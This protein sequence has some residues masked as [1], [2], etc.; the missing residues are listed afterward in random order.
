MLI[1]KKTYLSGYL[2]VYLSLILTVLISLCLTLILG[3]RENTRRMQIESVTD[4]GMNNLLAEYHRELLKQYNLFF[5]DTSYGTNVASYEESARHLKY[6]VHMN[7]ER[8]DIFLSSLLYRDLLKLK[9]DSVRVLNVSVASDEDGAVLRRQAV[10]VMKQ[11]IGLTYIQEVRDWYAIVQTYDMTQRDI[12]QE[13]KQAR[14]ELENWYG[15]IA[16]EY[17][18]EMEVHREIPGD[19][20]ASVWEAGLLNLIVDDIAT[21]SNLSVDL[22]S[23]IS[24]RIL[25][26]G[27]GIPEYIVFEDNW[28]DQLLFHEYVLSYTGR[29]DHSK[30]QSLLKYQTEY[31]LVGNPNDIQ[32]L[33]SIAYKLLALRGAA[34][35]VYLTSDKEKMKL[36]ELTAQILSSFLLIPEA[37]P[38]MQTVLVLTWA[39]AESLYDVTQ[40]FHGNKIPL[41]KSKESWHYSLDEILGFGWDQMLPQRESGLC[42]AD[43][44]RILLC[45]QDKKTTTFRLMDIMEM[46]IRQTKGNR[47]FRMDGSIDSIRAALEFSGKDGKTYTIERSYGY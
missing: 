37:A 28:I 22:T 29:Y 41:I 17:D 7:L 40:L 36:I 15:S 14:L 24:T 44:L 18:S 32:N 27:S 43:Y 12:Y 10:E 6:Y 11:K 21:L 1:M 20:V 23:Y 39:M 3:V 33:K 45:L 34:N 35:M 31:I 19:T 42:Y 9:V 26:S 4:I 47:F 13:Q 8:K 5:I 16:S 46:D 25:L 38:L 2:T 30:E